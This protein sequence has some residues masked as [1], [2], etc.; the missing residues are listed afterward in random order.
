MSLDRVEAT[1]VLGL[2]LSLALIGLALVL[3][4]AD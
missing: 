2:S 3:S 1:I 4:W